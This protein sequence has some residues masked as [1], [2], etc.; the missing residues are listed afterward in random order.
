MMRWKGIAMSKEL[1]WFYVFAESEAVVKK[2]PPELL[3]KIFVMLYEY[4]KTEEEPKFDNN[5]EFLSFQ[6]L[7][8]GVDV[9]KQHFQNRS[10]AGK[11]GME[12][13][14]HSNTPPTAKEL[15]KTKL[16]VVEPEP[17]KPK[18]KIFKPPTVE[19]VKA[20]CMERK[21]GIDPDYF[22][23]YY[24]RDNWIMKNGR[25]MSDW[26]AAV[27]TWERNNYSSGRTSTEDLTNDTSRYGED[28]DLWA[29]L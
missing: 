23:D 2:M 9:A 17:K 22:V 15:P 27:R 25:K 21:N 7:K 20:Y 4:A 18:T 12:S 28:S 11:K 14:W 1:T 8:K 26:K 19:E 16:N 5:E 24:Q 3:K 29:N 13:R 10:E 6:Y